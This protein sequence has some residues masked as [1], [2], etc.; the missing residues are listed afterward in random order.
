MN[1]KM[2]RDFARQMFLPLPQAPGHCRKRTFPPPPVLPPEPRLLCSDLITL[3][4][5]DSGPVP[6]EMAAIL[7]E[8][9]PHS[10][11]VQLEDPIQAGTAIRL[12]FTDSVEGGNLR[13]TVVKCDREENL[14]FFAEVAFVPGCT[15]SPLRYRPLHLLD[16]KHRLAA[17]GT[18]GGA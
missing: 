1:R 12:L 5:E 8:I 11:C 17:K 9:A 13:G 7:E 15:W 6:L 2:V 4:L 18:A 10:A 3:R 16:P 14:G